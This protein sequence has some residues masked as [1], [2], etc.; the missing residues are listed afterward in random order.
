[1]ILDPIHDLAR[2]LRLPGTLNRKRT[3]AEPVMLL[4][5]QTTYEYTLKDLE[6]LLPPLCESAGRM[7][8]GLS[9]GGAPSRDAI[10]D[11]SDIPDGRRNTTLYHVAAQRLFHGDPPKRVLEFIR[12]LNARRCQPP[13]EDDEVVRI[14]KSAMNYQ[15]RKL[16]GANG[17]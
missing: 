10:A 14:V 12:W 4:L 8:H 15:L 16:Q 13:L 17:E 7:R 11:L 2:V 6:R 9:R 3:P 1:V 5:N